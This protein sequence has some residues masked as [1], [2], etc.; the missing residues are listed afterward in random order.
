M[1]K[2][3]G[4]VG[5]AK[6]REFYCA[7]ED[8]EQ[9]NCSWEA[10]V[11]EDQRS[12]Q[13]CSSC[14]SKALEAIGCVNGWLNCPDRTKEMLVK[15]SKDHMDWCVKKGIHPNDTGYSPGNRE[16]VNKTRAKNTSSSTMAH[17]ANAHKNW[18]P[19]RR[20]VK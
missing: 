9:H 14:G 12:E 8:C 3:S 16:W 1:S 19:G 11:K 20:P 4:A 13:A 7:N 15:R 5:C 17:F 10:F 6:I 2:S 18:T